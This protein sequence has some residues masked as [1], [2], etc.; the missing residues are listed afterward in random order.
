[1]Y[2]EF[3]SFEELKRQVVTDKESAGVD[4]YTRNRYPIRFVLFDNFRDS[5]MFVEYVQTEMH[6]VLESVDKWLDADYPDIMI[7]HTQLAEKFKQYIKKQNGNDCIIAP[8]SELARFYDNGEKKTFDALLKTIKAIESNVRGVDLHQRV[9]VPIVGLEG[10]METFCQDTQST[11]WRLRSETKELTYR[12]V[13]TNSTTFGVKGLDAHYT[14]VNNV[15][16]WLNLWKDT[17]RQMTPN[18]ICT[19]PSIFANA[20]YAQPDNAFSYVSCHDA[21][22]F[23]VLGLQLQ[24]GSVENAERDMEYWKQL[25]EE[26]NLTNG[27]SFNRYV[28]DY[29]AVNG[30]GSYQQFIKL[31]FDYRNSF[32]RW[33]L[34]KYYHCQENKNDF[35]CRALD[36]LQSFSGNEL[37]ESMAVDMTTVATEIEVRRYCLNEAAKRNVVLCERIAL[38]VK[39]RLEAIARQNGV[40]S[41]LRYFTGISS[42]EKELAL[43]WLSK[44]EISAS[45]VKPFFHD[46]YSYLSEPIGVAV[47]AAQWL[48]DYMSEYKKAKVSNK[49]TDGLKTLINS[50]NGDDVHFDSWY[51]CF[52]TV[53][54]L[55]ANRG[56]IEIFY[57]VDGLGVDW[58]P[59]VKEIIREKKSQNI[60]LNEIMVARS[61]LPSTTAVNKAE[62]QKLPPEGQQLHKVGD[63]DSFAHQ[64]V[65]TWP[66]YI[67]RELQLVRDIIDDITEKYNGKKIAIV[68]DHGL[69]YIPQLCDGI[70]LAGVVSDHHGRV[71]IKESG[72][73]CNDSNYFR[74]EDGEKACALNHRSL[75]GKVPKGQGIHGGCCPEEVLVPIF[76]V[77]SYVNAAEWSANLLTTELSG[78]DPV[79]RFRIKNVPSTDIPYVSYNGQHYNLRQIS[80][81]EFET[82][83]VDVVGGNTEVT[84]TIGDVSRLF[85]VNVSTGVAEDDLFGDLL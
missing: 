29:F 3:L 59:F 11:I 26:I 53:R 55:L 68:S 60:F 49:Y 58:I 9:Y 52:S 46:L 10:K 36:K 14:I 21:Y 45:E 63:L 18:I 6:A 30:I 43:S 44:G 65:N 80:D 79:L 83:A 32:E 81:E 20:V 1:M 85:T 62:L 61:L 77:S 12:L 50:Y 78:A 23:L 8:F 57:W 47:G 48:S 73:F 27:F 19:S 7:T 25:A 56:D 17:K 13:L 5:S 4:A 2:S 70:G 33:L 51:Q 67:I 16:E 31:W 28:E 66:T 74:L 64:S 15:Q 41:A 54:S 76:V 84:L 37:V 22:E 38:L 71:A 35:V 24:F 34:C 72:T 75:C 82:G 42:K 69:S 39:N 40:T